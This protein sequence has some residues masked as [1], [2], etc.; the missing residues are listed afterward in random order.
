MARKQ[1][2][3]RPLHELLP[4][5]EFEGM[6]AEDKQKNQGNVIAAKQSPAF[7]VAGGLIAHCLTK[8]GERIRS[9]SASVIGVYAAGASTVSR[10]RADSR[11]SANASAMRRRIL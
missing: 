8:N 4:P 7:P 3:E 11:R 1:A 9:C 10:S 2:E 6:G 5:V